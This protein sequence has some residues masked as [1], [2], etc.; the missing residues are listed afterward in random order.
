MARKT[1]VLRESLA[2]TS[3]YSYVKDKFLDEGVDLNVYVN[4]YNQQ[5]VMDF[6]QTH[7]FKVQLITDEYTGGK[8]QQ[9]IGYEHHWKF[10]LAEKI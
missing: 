5:E 1:L 3:Q 8:P 2:E 10:M 7:G 4:T 6:I 9:V